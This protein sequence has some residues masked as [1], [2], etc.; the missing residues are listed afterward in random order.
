M[1]RYEVDNYVQEHSEDYNVNVNCV[2]SWRLRA[3]A[4]G[5]V[6]SFFLNFHNGWCFDLKCWSGRADAPDRLF[7]VL[8]RNDRWRANVAAVTSLG[9]DSEH[10]DFETQR[11]AEG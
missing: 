8:E 7:R 9:E 3:D 6:E 1:H 5:N 11:G 10:M 4:S 2:A